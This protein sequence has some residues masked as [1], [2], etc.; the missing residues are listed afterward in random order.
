MMILT[1]VDICILM[2]IL[3]FSV[4]YAQCFPD[5]MSKGYVSLNIFNEGLGV[6]L[7]QLLPDGREMNKSSS[8]TNTVKSP[9]HKPVLF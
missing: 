9:T 3:T 2:L 1:S 6:Q 7:H 8:K 4:L 5:M